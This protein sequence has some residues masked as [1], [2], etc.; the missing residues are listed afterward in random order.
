MKRTLVALSLMLL[1]VPAVAATFGVG[2][3][4][5]RTTN[6][7]DTCD[8]AVMPAATLLLP[9]F[10]V[11]PGFPSSRSTIFSVINVTNVDQIAR[12]TLW[13]DYSYPVISFNIYLTGYDVQSIN[14]FDVIVRGIIAPDAGTGTDVT[15]RGPLS[16]PNPALALGSCD[17]LPGALDPVFVERMQR[18]LIEGV[19]P[20]LGPFSS[21]DNA[22]GV[23]QFATG[24]ATIDVVGNCL[25]A[26]P[27]EPEYW[28][29]DIRYDN[30]LTGEYQQIDLTATVAQINPLVHIRAIPEGGTPSSRQHGAHNKTNFPR[31]FYDRYSPASHSDGRQPLPSTFAARWIEGPLG[32]QTEYKIWREGVTGTGSACSAYAQNA[33]LPVREVVVFDEAENFVAG[34]L[35]TPET[36]LVGINDEL[37]PMTNGATGGWTYFNL[38]TTAGDGEATQNWVVVSLRSQAGFGGDFDATVLGNGCTPEQ[39]LSEA[40]GGPGEI[41]PAPN[42]N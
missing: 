9:Y 36:S 35:T 11:D 7:D 15:D 18:A 42:N 1:T 12:V 31:T 16:D 19:V 14:L 27:T 3:G 32:Y 29:R 22:G 41:G 25:F 5:P 8:I 23:H 13:T 24:Y 39:G 21:C 4:G 6:N 17:R 37:P 2:H 26:Q 34:T 28:T 30:V 38:D 20:P 40:S 33:S 10:E